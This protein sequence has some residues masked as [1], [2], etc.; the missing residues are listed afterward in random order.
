MIF[1]ICILPNKFKKIILVG[2]VGMGSVVIKNTLKN[3]K[4]FGNPAK[5]YKKNF[6]L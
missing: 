3:K 6:N 4:Y 1:F 2:F 5:I